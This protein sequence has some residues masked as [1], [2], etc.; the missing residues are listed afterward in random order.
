MIV[1]SRV[2]GAAASVLLLA[3]A[4]ASAQESSRPTEPA[5]TASTV[6]SGYVKP[7][8]KHEKYGLLKVVVPVTTDDKGVQGMK[9]RNLSNSYAAAEQWGGKVEAVVV[10]YAKGVS[11]L[12][13]PSKEVEAQIDDLKKKGARFEVCNNTLREQGIDY[14]TLY[15]VAESDIVPSGFAEVAY[16]QAHKHFVVDPA[17]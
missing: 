12:K 16:L 9:L 11:M 8:I 5:P 1:M 13:N 6:S 15:H 2:F 14:R 10:L 3:A 4:S 7:N 17:S